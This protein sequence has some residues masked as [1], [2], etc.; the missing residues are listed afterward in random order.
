MNLIIL[1]LKQLLLLPI[2]FYSF[3]LAMAQ[4]PEASRMT[5]WTKA[6]THATLPIYAHIQFFGEASGTKD[7]SAA[8]QA[9]LD[10][11]SQPTIVLLGHGTFFFK[12]KI[13]L[14]G[15]TVLKGLG[16]TN[17]HL[18][19]NQEGADDPSIQV[20]GTESGAFYPLTIASA[21]DDTSILV[22]N[23]QGNNFKQ[24]DYFRLLQD[25]AD[26]IN[27][28]WAENRTGQMIRVDSVVSGK[29]YF[30]SQL[31]DNYPLNRNPRI[32][33]V[34]MLRFSGVECLKITREDYT[35]TGNGSSNFDLRYVSDFRLSGVESIK[36][37]Y[38]HAEV[39]YS[40]NVTIE[41]N[42]FYDAHNFGANGRGYGVMLH[43][44]TGEVL[45]QN[46]IFRRLRHA[47]ILQGGA[48]G[49]VFAYNYS[50]EGRKEIIPG[51]LYVVGED[52]VCHGNYPYLNLFEGNYA[53]FGSVDASHGKNGPF[54][55]FFR[56]VASH[57]GFVVSGTQSPSQNFTGNHTLAGNNSFSGSN[58]HITN[59]SWQG[60][61]SLSHQSLAYAVTPAFLEGYNQAPI[62]PHSFSDPISIPAQTRSQAGTNITRNCEVITWDG[63]KWQGGFNPSVLTGN[64][65]LLIMDG[66]NAIITKDAEI[67]SIEILPGAY[68]EVKP[69]VQVKIGQ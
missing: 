17:T 59:N 18:R 34:T 62:G 1:R 51:F 47:M 41:D 29:I 9:I 32:R 23:S 38:A 10:T 37:N 21:K 48:N 44:S 58:H 3:N 19:F 42:Y 65:K 33:K 69:T 61:S 20:R 56:N 35:N 66:S 31:R 25:N 40:T 24:G 6:G 57:S 60:E 50:Y 27:D 68:L 7:N 28:E 64:Y 30:S 15:N 53:Q 43:Y 8:L 12:K 52:M 49:N 4:L 22:S 67:K 54:N 26:L 14:K 63:K 16:N 39:Y 13:T 2:I 45:V 5:D 55:T 46:N 11:I 36:C